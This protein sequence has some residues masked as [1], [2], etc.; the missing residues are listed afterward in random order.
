MARTYYPPIKRL[1]KLSRQELLDLMFD[2]INALRIVRTPMETAF[3]IQD[4]LT[5]DEIKDL[6]KRL[7]IAKLLLQNRTQREIAQ[8]VKVSPATVNK[9]NLWMERGGEGFKR[10]ISKLPKRYEMPKGLPPRPLTFNLPDTL[11]T[12]GAFGLAKNQ[13]DN[14]EKFL[15]GVEDKQLLDKGIRQVN[16]EIFRK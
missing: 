9:V 8:I 5:A 6:A 11:L 2:L 14:L 13:Q 12:L 1:E 16:T 10:V 15:T 3:L 4:L 7:R